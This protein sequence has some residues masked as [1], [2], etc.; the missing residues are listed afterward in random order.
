LLT[1]DAWNRLTVVS[2]GAVST[3]Y[4]YDGQDRRIAS[5]TSGS[6]PSDGSVDFYYSDAWQVLEERHD[7]SSQ[8]ASQHVWG[9]RYADDLVLRDRDASGAG[10]GTLDERLYAMQDPNW[11]VT[12]VAD[13]G[14]TIVER[15]R[16]EPYGTRAVLT[17][18]FLP[19][20]DSSFDWAVGYAGYPRDSESGLHSVR[21]RVLHASLGRWL[22]RDPAGYGA[23]DWSLYRYVHGNPETETDWIGLGCKVDYKC[24]LVSIAPYWYCELCMW[25]CVETKR[26]T[27][28]GGTLTCASKKIPKSLSPSWIYP[29][30]YSCVTSYNTSVN[31]Y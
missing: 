8:P 24:T 13:A 5:R 21:F 28:A 30:R 26:T 20:S 4:T 17:P 25:N 3:H 7:G 19:R 10:G 15:C 16:Y 9:L 6:G 31:Y 22:S 2:R 18:A 1:F 11:N 23:E 29:R 27:I 14:G 12:A